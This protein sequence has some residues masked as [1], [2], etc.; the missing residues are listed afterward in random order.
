MNY[1]HLFKI[2]QKFRINKKKLVEKFYKLQLKY[3]PDFIKKKDLNKKKKILISI[4]INQGFKVLKNK[5]LRAKHLLKIKKK[6]YCIK[7][8]KFF[9]QDQILFKQFQLHEKIENIKKKINSLTE[10]NNLIEKLNQKIKFYFL[11]FNEMIK[12]KKINY[13]E[14]FLFKISFSYKILK[15]AKKSKKQIL[16][17]N[18]K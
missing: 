8:E 14:K 1:F 11:K 13:A 6:K 12:N 5:F 10:I 7:E 2:P 4:K 18:K 17:R 16:H 3:H 9:N 15:K